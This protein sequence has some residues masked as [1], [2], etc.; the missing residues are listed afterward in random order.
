MPGQGVVKAETL[1]QQESKEQGGK[2]TKRNDEELKKMGLD[3]A[4]VEG[5]RREL[6][7]V[8]G[9]K[10]WKLEVF[11]VN[12]GQRELRGIVEGEEGEGEDETAEWGSEEYKAQGEDGGRRR[13]DEGEEGSEEVYKDEL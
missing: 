2:L 1:A 9:G 12:E 4:V 3:P 10:G 8:A 5:Y 7:N 11:E 13:D 6:A